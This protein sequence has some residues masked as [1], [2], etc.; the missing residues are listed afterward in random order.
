MKKSLP[1]LL[2]KLSRPPAVHNWVKNIRPRR[3]ATAFALHNF[4]INPPR[5]SLL[6]TVSICVAIVVDGISITQALKC[7]DSIKDPAAQ[8][9]A[10]WI[11]KAFHSEKERKGWAGIQIFRDMIEFFPV[12][13]GVRVPV[14]PTF[15]VNDNGKLVPYFLICWA[16]MDL[17]PYQKRI[18]ST[19]ISEAILSLEEFRGSDAVIICTPVAAYSKN[20]RSIQTWKASGWPVLN[21]EEK[22]ALFDRYAGAMADA[23]KM[24]IESLG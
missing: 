2:K 24:I 6:S 13:A 3:D 21:D 11:L 20:E 4:A 16:K 19:L 9:R 12:S 22:Q 14:K 23:E 15:V 10:K 1:K 8:Q 5:T 18:L 17:T 7:S